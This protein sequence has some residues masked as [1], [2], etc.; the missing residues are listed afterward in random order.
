MDEP[1]TKGPIPR[2][3][4]KSIEASNLRFASCSISNKECTGAGYKGPI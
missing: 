2:W 1:I 4:K 3:Q